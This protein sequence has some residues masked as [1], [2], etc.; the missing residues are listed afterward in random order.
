MNSSVSACLLATTPRKLSILLTCVR[1]MKISQN[2]RKLKLSVGSRAP[3]QTLLI[4]MLL[5][6][7]TFQLL[8]WRDDFVLGL[9]GRM[10]GMEREKR[11]IQHEVL[12]LYVWLTFFFCLLAR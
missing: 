2:Q 6:R 9:V 5:S 7:A 4:R 3:S 1:K 8:A 12:G 11:N 10:G